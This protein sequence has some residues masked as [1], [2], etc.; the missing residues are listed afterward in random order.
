MS[1]KVDAAFAE[2]DEN[3]NL[4]PRERL[5]AQQV[6]NDMR[7]AVSVDRLVVDSFLQ[8]S[9][10]RKTMLKP[11][12]DVDVVLL[13]N[14]ELRE[15]YRA[16]DGPGRAMEDFKPR[17]L[18]K[19]PDAEFDQGEEPAGKA[20]RVSL[21]NCAFTVDLVPAFEEDPPTEY[22]L[23]GDRHEGSWERSNTRIQ[24]RKVSERNKAT[25]WR[26]VHQV[27]MLKAYRKHHEGQLEFVSGIVMESLAFAAIRTE[28]PHADAVLT[29]LRHAATAVYGPVYEPAG[30]DDV[31]AKWTPQQRSIAAQAFSEAAAR[32]DEA[33]RLD[34]AGDPDGAIDAWHTLLGPDFPKPPA[35]PLKDA[36]AAW[37]SGSVSKTGRPSATRAADQQAPAG[38]S[39][40]SR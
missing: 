2:F 16:P 22:V 38:R 13:L 21:P 5:R 33:V 15:R 30:E 40:A 32:A 28:L 37:G 23:I 9:F 17:V 27:R 20:L 1:K 10:A 8:G 29:T 4:D 34:A 36:A 6:H 7:D 31:T 39:W 24:R 12:K 26:F 3:L 19:F 18:K 14:P 25:G 11:L 35:R